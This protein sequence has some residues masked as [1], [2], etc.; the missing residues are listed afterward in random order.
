[1]DF[2]ARG[3]LW[4][5]CTHLLPSGACRAGTLGLVSVFSGPLDEA[6]SL[7]PSLLLL[8]EDFHAG[9]DEAEAGGQLK[10]IAWT[11]ASGQLPVSGRQQPWDSSRTSRAS[12][13][14]RRTLWVRLG[15]LLTSS[16][17]S[18]ATS[19][20]VYFVFIGD[21][22]SCCVRRSQDNFQVSVLSCRVS[23]RDQLKSSGL[24]MGPFVHWA[25]LPAPT[26]LFTLL[27]IELLA[28]VQRKEWVLDHL[29]SWWFSIFVWA[30]WLSRLRSRKFLWQ[31]PSKQDHI[32]SGAEWQRDRR[33]TEQ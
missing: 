20:I 12:L 18:K 9:C 22:L 25:I 33:K 4:L 6:I 30:T 15:E 2:K 28:S 16:L 29:S 10:D 5:L 8:L 14:R 31:L 27:W 7:T 32:S 11:E 1:M 19:L 21:G 3:H 23:P 17:F 13:L 26:Y 24:E